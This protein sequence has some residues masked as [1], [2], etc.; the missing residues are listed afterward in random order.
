MFQ[1]SML[2]F[3]FISLMSG[4]K[5][6]ASIIQTKNTTLLIDCGGPKRYLMEALMNH[7]ITLDSIDACFITHAHSDHI[8][9]I[10]TFAHKPIYSHQ[11]IQGVNTTQIS[12]NDRIDVNEC[13]I[14]PFSL[15]H[16]IPNVGYIIH[17][18]LCKI[19]CVTDTGYLRNDD[20]AL[21]HN[22]HFYY[23][24]SNYEPALLMASSRPHLVKMRTLSD[25][26]HLSNEDSARIMKSLIGPQTHEVM[27][28]HISED[29]NT[30]SLA[31]RAHHEAWFE[32]YPHIKLQCAK[33]FEVTLGGKYD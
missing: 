22:A 15:S 30:L 14:T 31:L 11:P 23:F 5:G 21:L 4:S 27:L 8:Q 33:Q 6:N 13:I 25:S 26:G 2:D 10:K 9:Q 18:Q 16:D 32:D 29:A 7:G 1:S 17:T 20:I 19:V 28:A 24:E 12:L 3:K